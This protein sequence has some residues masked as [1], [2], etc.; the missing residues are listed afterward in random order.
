MHHLSSNWFE[1]DPLDF[2]LF[3]VPFTSEF[4]SSANR[5]PFEFF[6][7]FFWDF[8]E[9]PSEILLSF[10]L[11]S[12]WAAS[13]FLWISSSVRP[14]WAASFEFKLTL[15]SC[16]FSQKLFL[17]YF[18]DQ[19][20]PVLSNRISCSSVE[21]HVAQWK[22]SLHDLAILSTVQSAGWSQRISHSPANAINTIVWSARPITRADREAVSCSPL[23]SQLTGVKGHSC[24]S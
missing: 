8:L 24:G 23:C 6:M 16:L 19:S 14:S 15:T 10:L 17:N 1:Q 21:S 4:L 3:T 5:M 7:R 20:N 18:D 13:K 9:F 11:N 12:F 22:W 2:F